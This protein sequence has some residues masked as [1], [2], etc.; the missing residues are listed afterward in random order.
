MDVEGFFVKRGECYVKFGFSDLKDE[1]ESALIELGNGS[2]DVDVFYRR[3]TDIDNRFHPSAVPPPSFIMVNNRKTKKQNEPPLVPVAVVVPVAKNIKKTNLESKLNIAVEP[4]LESA[5]ETFFIDTV[6]KG[7]LNVINHEL[8]T[9]GGILSSHLPP[10]PMSLFSD[11]EEA[12]ERKK[13]K[14]QHEDDDDNDALLNFTR[15]VISQTRDKKRIIKPKKRK[16]QNEQNKVNVT[17]ALLY[18]GIEWCIF[19]QK[20]PPMMA[21]KLQRHFY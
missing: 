14:R 4:G 8:E 1:L 16:T 11:R 5:L 12:A 3:Y 2:I 6:K 18:R 19:H 7:I 10:T 21:I 15:Q 13:K 9:R 17:K 20:I